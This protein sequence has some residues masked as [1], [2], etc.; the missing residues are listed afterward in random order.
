MYYISKLN[1]PFGIH[2]LYQFCSISFDYK[3]E[4]DFKKE[5]KQ[6]VTYSTDIGSHNKCFLS[7]QSLLA[8][9]FGDI[10]KVMCYI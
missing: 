2:V 3:H 5:K 10:F 8:D 4:E 9:C 6:H 1:F 7:V